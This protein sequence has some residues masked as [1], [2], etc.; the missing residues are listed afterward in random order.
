MSV[1]DGIKQALSAIDFP[2]QKEDLVRHAEGA[3]AGEEVLR[4][5]RALPL[6]EYRNLDEVLRSTPDR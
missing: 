5:L 1:D 3:G 6:A 2:V 4:A